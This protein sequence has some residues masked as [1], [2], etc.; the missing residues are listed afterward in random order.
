MLENRILKKL[1]YQQKTGLYRQ[2]FQIDYRQGKYIYIKGEKKLNFTSNDYLGLGTSEI[3]R[4][5][6]ALNF[7]KYGPSSSS[8]RLV[9]GNYQA[10]T[11]AEHAFAEYF[12][13]ESALF[14][15][16]G[17]QANI[18][19]LSTLF[20]TGDVIFFDKHIHASSVKGMLLSNASLK[21]YQHNSMM[22][23]ERRLNKSLPLP[24]ACNAQN[25]VIAVLTESLF[26]MDGDFLAIDSLA[27]LRT[28]F[29]FFCII[30][31]AHA[32]GAIGDKGRGIARQTA[33]I[34]VGTFGKALGLFGAFVLGPKWVRDCLINFS[35]PLIY[36]TALPEA[37]GAS[38]LDLLQIVC[39]S[40]DRR[41]KLFHA[42]RFM[43][44]ELFNEGFCVKGDAHLLALEIGDEMR[45]VELSQ[46]LL[47]R[48]FL[49]FPARFPTVPLGKAIIRISMNALHDETDIKAFIQAI[50]SC[51]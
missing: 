45:T 30:D 25:S 49:A 4:Q 20:E 28:R 50:K 41:E 32:F 43:K 11:E 27:K 16:S 40:D 38:A 5:K 39:N 26:S 37:H 14:F 2:P 7:E 24:P 1:A 31:E 9:S 6:V 51:I 18:G 8:S 10:I 47:N 46:H 22:H 29:G 33:D 12:G 42:S 44:Q 48:G 17:Y 34:A 15:P 13:Y 35:S 19:I 3:L 21:G 23:L 36:T